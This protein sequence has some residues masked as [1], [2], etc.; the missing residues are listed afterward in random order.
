MNYPSS[1]IENAVNELAKLPGIG[2]KSALRFALHLL[3]QENIVAENLATSIL[4]LKKN[5]KFCTN[6][7]NISDGDV[8]NI[9]SSPKRDKSM[10]CVVED[11]KDVLAIENTNQYFGVYHVLGGVISP[12]EGISPSHL[13]IESLIEKIKTNT[14]NEIILA[15]SSTME[16][17]TTAYYI[18]KKVKDLNVKVTTI[19]RGIPVGGELEFADEIT[20]GRSITRR[21]D[22]Q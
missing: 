11:L 3:K 5:T 14:I 19:A 7:H 18:S 13:K 10:V 17:D 12:L 20:L 21:I 15:L 1:T 6:C 9:C 8:C 22:F 4:E 2:K 16:G